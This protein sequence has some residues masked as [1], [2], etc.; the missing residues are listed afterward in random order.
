[1]PHRAALNRRCMPAAILTLWPGTTVIVAVAR[2]RLRRSVPTVLESTT[3]S[4]MSW[5][6]ARIGTEGIITTLAPV[7]IH[8]DLLQAPTASCAA[9][10]GTSTPG[11]AVR[12]FAVGPYQTIAATASVSGWFFLQVSDPPSL[13]LRRTS[14]CSIEVVWLRRLGHRE[15]LSMEEIRRTWS[16]LWLKMHHKRKRTP[17]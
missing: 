17:A 11:T 15:G 10:A 9:A 2:T 16:Y 13:K 6:G 5:S 12:P 8:A 4:A 7:A 1:M 14:L 3:L